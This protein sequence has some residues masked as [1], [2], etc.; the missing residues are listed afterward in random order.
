MSTTATAF[1]NPAIPEPVLTTSTS[2]SQFT[3]NHLGIAKS[4]D[5]HTDAADFAAAWDVLWAK[6]RRSRST[7]R[8]G[9][10]N[11]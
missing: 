2:S 5:T 4:S 11:G 10:T 7:D 9:N 3:V 6:F 1:A 8:A